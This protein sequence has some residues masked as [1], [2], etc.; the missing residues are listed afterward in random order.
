MYVHDYDNIYYP[1]RQ[2]KPLDFGKGIRDLLAKIGSATPDLSCSR[3]VSWCL[4]PVLYK[5]N[6]ITQTCTC[7]TLKLI[8]IEAVT[9]QK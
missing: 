5:E 6:V 9:F 7:G 4:G 1:R 8:R 2:R 3:L